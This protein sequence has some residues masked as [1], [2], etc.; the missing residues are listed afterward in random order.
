MKNREDKYERTNLATSADGEFT[1][2]SNVV[3]KQIHQTQLVAETDQNVESTRMKCNAVCFLRKLLVQ[4]QITET[5][6]AAINKITQ[7]KLLQH[8]AETLQD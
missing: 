4:L 2:C 7:S 3:D 5:K 1:E 6:I 8:R